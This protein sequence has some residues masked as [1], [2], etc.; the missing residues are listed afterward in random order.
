MTHDYSNVNIIQTKHMYA[1]KTCSFSVRSS[2]STDQL[3]GGFFWK[4]TSMLECIKSLVESKWDQSYL[5]LT[6]VTIFVFDIQVNA[7][8]QIKKTSI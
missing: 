3:H 1:F 4:G 8:Q 2:V 7:R 5:V 6:K